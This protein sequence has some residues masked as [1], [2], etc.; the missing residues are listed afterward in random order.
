[1]KQTGIGV[2]IF[3]LAAMAATLFTG[4]EIGED[5]DDCP[6]DQNTK[7]VF[8]YQNFPNPNPDDENVSFPDNIGQVT[9][10]IYD[11]EGNFVLEKV[12]N[13]PQDVTLSLPPGAY[14]AVCWGN[15]LDNTE[16]DG[17]TEGSVIDDG[18]VCHPNYSGAKTYAP[19][20][21]I[22]TNDS[23]YY[24]IA[25]FTK[26][27]YQ[28]LRV[29]VV[30]KPAHIKL[31][32]TV[33]GLPNTRAGTPPQDYPVIRVNKLKA[34]YDFEMNTLGASV[35]YYPRVEVTAQDMAVSQCNVL[36]FATDNPVTI[37]VIRSLADNTTL[38]SINLK[39]LLEENN[40]TIVDG[41]EVFIPVKVVFSNLGNV[42]VSL[43]G[44]GNMPVTPGM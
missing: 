15:A 30:F 7:L 31:K 3:M 6:P 2:N 18:R 9:T 38:Q 41:E 29:T 25:T 13:T 27:L 5:R 40:K 35:S 19:G 17:L 12:M 22:P 42:E 37:D 36:R 32:V 43:A 11:S 4:C 34:V 44:W 8:G 26:I 23:L 10:G 14:T 20:D 24:G 39:E 1:M 33:Q 28:D 16:I 21:A